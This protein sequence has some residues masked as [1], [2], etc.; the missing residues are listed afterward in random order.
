MSAPSWN[1][2]TVTA[3]LP[4]EKVAEK[5]TS[6]Y[7]LPVSGPAS[8]ASNVPHCSTES[9]VV[10]VF[11]EVGG[12][13]L[14]RADG[15]SRYEVPLE[16]QVDEHGGQDRHDDGRVELPVVARELALE[17]H[18]PERQGP[19]ASI[20]EDHQGHGEL[21][22]GGDEVEDQERRQHRQGQRQEDG[23]K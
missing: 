1:P 12:L 19:H 21:V 11:L 4:S 3:R 7:G 13:L 23:P 20:L 15:Q 2:G 8:A 9:N 22:P 10:I 14:D 16:D 5:R 6:R 17:G 18:E